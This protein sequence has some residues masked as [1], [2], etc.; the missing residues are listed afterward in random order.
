MPQ[1]Q[2]SSSSSSRASARERTRRKKSSKQAHLFILLSPSHFPERDA[3]LFFTTPPPTPGTVARI[4]ARSG[5]VR[6]SRQCVANHKGPVPR[7][8]ER[9][10]RPVIGRQREDSTGGRAPKHGWA[11]AQQWRR[12]FFFASSPAEK[13]TPGKSTSV[14]CITKWQSLHW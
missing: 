4:G 2:T 7:T 6:G 9:R 14:V 12:E 11:E 10:R 1:S 5:A 8:S 3:F 13:A